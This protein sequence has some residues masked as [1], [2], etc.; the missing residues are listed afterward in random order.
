MGC[1]SSPPVTHSGF[2]RAALILGLVATSGTARAG[3]SPAQL[4]T[5][6]T[7]IEKEL[8]KRPTRAVVKELH[9]NAGIIGGVR[10][11]VGA[12]RIREG[13]R[14]R[15]ALV[16]S[17]ELIKD[18][19]MGLALT[20]ST[21]TVTA[22]GLGGPA[23]PKSERVERMGMV[24]FAGFGWATARSGG[25]LDHRATE[26]EVG[27]GVHFTDTER[28]SDSSDHSRAGRRFNKV[29]PFGK[30]TTTKAPRSRAERLVDRARRRL[31]SADRHTGWRRAFLLDRAERFLD[32]AETTAVVVD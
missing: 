26:T 31:D 27:V 25:T 23:I 17:V 5:R 1:A 28:G 32:R 8:A 12:G 18:A 21:R 14:S 22:S 24:P 13:A 16:G 29:I 19:S 6:A 3:R 7:R 15:R 2:L 20:A 9:L 11:S 10:I 30:T 4:R